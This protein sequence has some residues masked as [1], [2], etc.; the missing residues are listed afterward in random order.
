MNEET[1]TIFVVDDDDALRR[2]L[3]RQIRGPNQ[4]HFI[5]AKLKITVQQVLL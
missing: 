1:S 5:E 3:T 2:A 4:I